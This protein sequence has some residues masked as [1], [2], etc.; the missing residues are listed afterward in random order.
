M[1]SFPSKFGAILAKFEASHISKPVEW[2]IRQGWSLQ[3]AKAV[4][5]LPSSPS[6]RI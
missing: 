5:V 6:V 2:V 4:G 3:I 1:V